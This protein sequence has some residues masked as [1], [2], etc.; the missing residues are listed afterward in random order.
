MNTIMLRHKHTHTVC[1]EGRGSM[2]GYTQRQSLAARHLLVETT[3]TEKTEWGRDEDR[4]S[5]AEKQRV[6]S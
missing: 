6:D 3:K 2:F 1:A 4:V 5:K